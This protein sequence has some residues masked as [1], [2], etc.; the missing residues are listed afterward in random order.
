MNLTRMRTHIFIHNHS[1]IVILKK[2]ARIL[3]Q[4]FYIHIKISPVVP[5]TSSRAFLPLFSNP[6]SKND[7][8]D[9][10]RL[11]FF[12]VSFNLEQFLFLSV[13]HVSEVQKNIGQLSHLLALSH[14]CLMIWFFFFGLFLILYIY[15]FIFVYLWLHLI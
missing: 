12:L 13:F 8:L 5:K 6:G 4:L 14:C 1:I 3:Y 9:Y 2:L 11:L 7:F 10:I 15:L